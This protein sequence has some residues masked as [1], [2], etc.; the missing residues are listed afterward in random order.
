[1]TEGTAPSTAVRLVIG[2]KVFIA[3]RDLEEVK[4]TGVVRLDVKIFDDE[5]DR[6]EVANRAG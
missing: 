6:W 4:L 5:W 3:D 2:V 1:M